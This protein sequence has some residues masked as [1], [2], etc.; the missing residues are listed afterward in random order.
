MMTGFLLWRNPYYCPLTYGQYNIIIQFIHWMLVTWWSNQTYVWSL[1]CLMNTLQSNSLPLSNLASFNPGTS[2]WVRDILSSR[3][4][5]A[6]FTEFERETRPPHGRPTLQK[7]RYDCP[8]KTC[9]TCVI[10]LRD[11]KLHSTRTWLPYKK[12]IIK[13]TLVLGACCHGNHL[14]F[15]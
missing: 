13:Q 4:A 8:V 9:S 2:K 3:G 12:Q 11:I 1:L 6:K 7:S 5:S 14:I 15:L 10:A